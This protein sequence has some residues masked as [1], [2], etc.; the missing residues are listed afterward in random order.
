MG[1]EWNLHTRGFSL[2]LRKNMIFKTYSNITFAPTPS[3]YLHAASHSIEPQL[4]GPSAPSSFII[5]MWGKGRFT[6]PQG[7]SCQPMVTDGRGHD[8]APGPVHTACQGSTSAPQLQPGTAIPSTEATVWST[9]CIKVTESPIG[10]CMGWK[11]SIRRLILV[12]S[13]ILSRQQTWRQQWESRADTHH[14]EDDTYKHRHWCCCCNTVT[15]QQE[16]LHTDHWHIVIEIW[17]SIPLSLASL[18]FLSGPADV[19]LFQTQKELNKASTSLSSTYSF[20]ATVLYI[21]SFFCILYL[22]LL[23]LSCVTPLP[24]SL[25]GLTPP[26]V[27]I[28]HPPGLKISSV[29]TLFH[30]SPPV[31]YLLLHSFPTSPHTS[32]SIFI[33]FSFAGSTKTHATAADRCAFHTLFVSL[34]CHST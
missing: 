31:S 11:I 4:L 20:S 28:S 26:L 30:I 1:A 33:V 27:L 24:P 25:Q 14:W 9:I 12:N 7:W 32:S 34:F 16:T 23:F 17:V 15:K 29:P 13:S 22:P 18:V 10:A 21:S 5:L 19:T 8:R 3:Q 6:F 2:I